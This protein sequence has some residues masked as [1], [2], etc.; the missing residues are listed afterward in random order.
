MKLKPRK[1]FQ[2]R[3]DKAETVTPQAGGIAEIFFKIGG[4]FGGFRKVLI[5]KGD[6]E[7]VVCA[8]HT[9]WGNGADFCSIKQFSDD[10]WG[11]MIHFLLDE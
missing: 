6:G 7:A 1:I 3:D 11:Q 8:Y 4:Y 9:E 10:D 5:R 2:K